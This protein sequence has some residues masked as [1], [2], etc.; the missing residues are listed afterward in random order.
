ML[1]CECCN[2]AI[3]SRDL[4]AD[5]REDPANSDWVLSSRREVSEERADDYEAGEQR[6]PVRNRTWRGRTKYDSDAARGVVKAISIGLKLE[7]AAQQNGVSL[8]YAKKISAFWRKAIGVKIKGIA[9]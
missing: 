5:C 8:V 9:K 6:L 3:V 2:V 4:C 7:T 1:K